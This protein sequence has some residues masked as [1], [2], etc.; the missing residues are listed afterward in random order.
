MATY[1]ILRAY[2]PNGGSGGSVP[3]AVFLAAVASFGPHASL[4]MA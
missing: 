2:G 3:E 1:G 4:T